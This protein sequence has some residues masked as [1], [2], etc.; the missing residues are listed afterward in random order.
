MDVCVLITKILISDGNNFSAQGHCSYVMLIQQQRKF[1]LLKSILVDARSHFNR[2][3]GFSCRWQK[4]RWLT[5]SQSKWSNEFVLVRKW[6]FLK[7]EL[8]HRW[9]NINFIAIFRLVKPFFFNCNE[10]FASLNIALKFVFIPR[11]IGTSWKKKIALNRLN[12]L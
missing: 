2:V 3:Q 5:L 1:V 9:V 11:C 6:F 7:R 12:W 10:G 8:I 4:S